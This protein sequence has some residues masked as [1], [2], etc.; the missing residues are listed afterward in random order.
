[1][2]QPHICSMPECLSACHPILS[3]HRCPR[4][5]PVEYAAENVQVKM[6]AQDTGPFCTQYPKVSES[7]LELGG[8]TCD[9]GLLGSPKGSTIANEPSLGANK[10]RPI[11]GQI[12]TVS[13]EA[14][15]G[16]SGDCPIRPKRSRSVSGMADGP[17]F[18]R[19]SAGGKPGLADQERRT[20]SGVR[21]E[22][23]FTK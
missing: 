13:V 21:Q 15:S 3:V 10:I 6:L 2:P 1:M 20:A 18:N 23:F 5:L 12:K 14:P 8:L 22:E 17:R 4:S 11:R 16:T 9:E 19:R 7:G